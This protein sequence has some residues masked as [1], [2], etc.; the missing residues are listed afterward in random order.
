MI[1]ELQMYQKI[2]FNFRLF[3]NIEMQ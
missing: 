1:I 3:I 2:I